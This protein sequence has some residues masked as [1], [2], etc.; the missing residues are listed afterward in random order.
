MYIVCMVYDVD[1]MWKT[2]I[3]SSKPFEKRPSF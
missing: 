1:N 3:A 2:R